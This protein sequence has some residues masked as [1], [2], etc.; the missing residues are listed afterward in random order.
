VNPTPEGAPRPVVVRL[1]QL[2]SDVRL[3][4]ASFDQIWHDDKSVLGED[5]AKREEVE[6]YPSTRADLRFDRTP[7]IA[8]VAAVA[9]FQ[10]PR[11]RSWFSVF[12]LPPPPEAGKCDAR[13]CAGSEDPEDCATRA[14]ETGHYAFWIEASKVDDGI[15]HLDDFPRVGPMTRRRGP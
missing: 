12:D 1:Y 8:H 6:L 5:L 15:E 14:A 10:Q 7:E 3:Y 13:A 2:K 4:N 11:G 9:L